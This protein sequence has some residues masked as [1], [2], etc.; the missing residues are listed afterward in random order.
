MNNASEARR[1]LEISNTKVNTM[2]SN[3]NVAN[4]SQS[5]STVTQ[6]GPTKDQAIVI[7]AHDGIPIKDYIY[8]I[9]KLTEPTNIRF[10]SRISNNRICIYLANKKSVEEICTHYPR[11]EINNIQLEIAQLSF[12]HLLCCCQ[13]TQSLAV[14]HLEMISFSPIGTTFFCFVLQL[15]YLPSPS[16]PLSEKSCSLIF[17]LVPFILQSKAQFSIEQHY[18]WFGKRIKKKI[19]R[20]SLI[21]TVDDVTCFKPYRWFFRIVMESRKVLMA[22]SLM[23]K[24]AKD[25]AKRSYDDLAVLIWNGEIITHRYSLL[26]R[27]KIEE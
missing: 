17:L 13:F 19:L 4:P 26:R 6:S 24:L 10:V 15:M 7:E 3:P 27:N 21:Q 16:L 12:I 20:E 22:I 23:K 8:A 18:L 9:G 1:V 2:S 14:T 11:I 5:Y 25:K